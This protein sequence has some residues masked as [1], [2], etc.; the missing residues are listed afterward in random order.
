MEGLP[1]AFNQ[2]SDAFNLVSD[3][4][5]FV[6]AALDKVGLEERG[7]SWQAPLLQ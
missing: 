3:T 1:E 4:L 6:P 5:P 2:S 7:I